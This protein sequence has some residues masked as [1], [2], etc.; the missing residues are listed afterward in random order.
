MESIVIFQSHKF[1]GWCAIW[2]IKE[3]AVVTSGIY[4]LSFHLFQSDLLSNIEVFVKKTR[5]FR[6]WQVKHMIKLN[7]ILWSSSLF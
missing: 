7:M 6:R 1:L 5:Q 2:W 3:H 4:S